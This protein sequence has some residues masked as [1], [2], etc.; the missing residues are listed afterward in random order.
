MKTELDAVPGWL[1][2][3][4]MYDEELR[5]F[6]VEGFE[7]EVPDEDSVGEVPVD[8]HPLVVRDESRRYELRF[9]RPFAWQCSDAGFAV[10]DL[11]ARADDDGVV[12]VLEES[13]Y[14]ALHGAAGLETELGPY[15]HYRVLTEDELV[16]VISDAPPV[17]RAVDPSEL[18][19][20]G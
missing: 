18:E 11:G 13:A 8:S 10:E 9:P 15:R 1:F 3:G 2:E 7:D 5:L 6:L 16:D 12:Q 20:G 17:V 14:L 19:Q 4:A